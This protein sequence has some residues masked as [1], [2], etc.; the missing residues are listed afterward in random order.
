MSG[1]GNGGGVFPFGAL[2]LAPFGLHIGMYIGHNLGCFATVLG[3]FEGCPIVVKST[4]A[5]LPHVCCLI[6]SLSIATC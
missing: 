5:C 6:D 3:W 2:D 1:L 4:I